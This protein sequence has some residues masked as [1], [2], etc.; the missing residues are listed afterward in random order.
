MLEG[1]NQILLSL[2][3]KN[4]ELRE[5]QKTL[6]HELELNK[7]QWRY[8]QESI[9][10]ILSKLTELRKERENNDE[11]RR[12]DLQNKENEYKRILKE[13]NQQLE[14]LKRENEDKL[15]KLESIKVEFENL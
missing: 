11:K 5:I 8:K 3:K 12:I 15:K 10:Q 2:N 7:E 14:Y 9:E 1:F 13:K 6:L 4:L